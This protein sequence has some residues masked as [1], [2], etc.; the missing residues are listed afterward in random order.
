MQRLQHMHPRAVPA[1]AKLMST[2]RR[3]RPTQRTLLYMYVLSEPETPHWTDAA[4]AMCRARLH[5][6][7]LYDHFTLTQIL[8][9][10]AAALCLHAASA[11]APTRCRGC[12][13]CAPQRMSLLRHYSTSAGAEYFAPLPP[14]VVFN[15]APIKCILIYYEWNQK[16]IVFWK[17]YCIFAFFYKKIRINF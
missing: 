12:S 5:S 4:A 14:R 8:V 13:R 9:A 17:L 1:R 16:K 7:L 15:W 11:R 6:L 10:A 2:D 3:D